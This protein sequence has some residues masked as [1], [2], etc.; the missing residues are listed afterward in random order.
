MD[1]RKN[2][3]LE[4]LATERNYVGI[5]KQIVQ[6]F[7]EPL[8]E[9]SEST[10][11]F[12][13]KTD[14]RLLFSEIKVILALNKNFLKDLE[15]VVKKSSQPI[16]SPFLKYGGLFRWY[17]IYICNFDKSSA[18][19][20]QLIKDNVAFKEFIAQAEA[21]P[22][23]NYMDLPS[24]MI[25]PVQRIPQYNLLL[26]DIANNTSES[27]SDHTDT[28]RAVK[29]MNV[30]GHYINE[31]KR[32]SENI[33]KVLSIS[34]SIQGFIL[35]PVPSRRF[36]L[37]DEFDVLSE[38]IP[39][40]S[41]VTLFGFNDVVLVSTKSEN[42]FKVIDHGYYHDKVALMSDKALDQSTA[43]ELKIKSKSIQLMAPSVTRKSIWEYH[44]KKFS[45]IASKIK[46]QKAKHLRKIN[47]IQSLLTVKS[48]DLTSSIKMPKTPRNHKKMT[49]GK[50]TSDVSDKTRDSIEAAVNL[51][52]KNE[53]FNSID[54]YVKSLGIT[55]HYIAPFENTK[56]YK[57]T[58]KA[59]LFILNRSFVMISERCKIVE[60]LH[61]L[62][63]TTLSSPKHPDIIIQTNDQ[64]IQG[65]SVFCDDIIHQ[66]RKCFALS[67][68]GIPK[69]L[70]WVLDIEPWR[71]SKIVV[72]KEKIK[73]GGFERTYK[74]IC[75]WLNHTIRSDVTFDVSNFEGEEFNLSRL[76]DLSN[77]DIKAITMALWYNRYFKSFKCHNI[78]LGKDVLICI[79][80]L[81]RQNTVLEGVSFSHNDIS[82]DGSSVIQEFFS[83]TSRKLRY[84]EISSNFLEDKGIS[85][86]LKYLDAQK[87]CPINTLI[88]R[89]V[90]IGSK[91]IV[92]LFNR[93]K[94]TTSTYYCLSTLD[95]SGNKMDN[96]GSA[97]LAA[98][99][100]T[101]C[102]VKDLNI[103]DTQARIGPILQSVIKGCIYLQKL[104]ISK[105]K[106]TKKDMPPLISFLKKSDSLQSLDI[107]ET[108]I[109]GGDLAELLAT[110]SQNPYLN[111]VAVIA[112]HN[113][114]GS[115]GAIDISPYLD[116]LKGIRSLSLK[117]NDFADEGVASICKALRNRSCLSSLW[118]DGNFKF[119]N[120][121]SRDTMV[122]SLC[123]LV[124][125]KFGSLKTLS[126][127][128]INKNHS[129][130][131]QDII[132]IIKSLER[133]KLEVIDF[134]GHKMGNAGTYAL[135]RVIAV[136]NYLKDIKFDENNIG[137]EGLS[138]IVDSISNRISPLNVVIPIVDISQMI[139][140]ETEN[141]NIK[142]LVYSLQFK[143]LELS[144][145]LNLKPVDEKRESPIASIKTPRKAKEKH[146]S[147]H[148]PKK[149][150]SKNSP[151][152]LK[153]KDK[154]SSDS[155]LSNEIRNPIKLVG[156][157]ESITKR[158]RR[159][160]SSLTRT[161]KS[162]FERIESL[163][164]TA[165][166][167]LAEVKTIKSRDSLANLK[168][169]YALK[170][171]SPTS[172][173]TGSNIEFG[174][175][176]EMDDSDDSSHSS[177]DSLDV[178]S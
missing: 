178:D 12:I 120:A 175:N 31:K 173:K 171:T 149:K 172:T 144:K 113:G 40:V 24:L 6:Y 126:I 107:S 84:L 97:A 122:H 18:T 157:A 66:I 109:S 101:P 62:D 140:S 116:S 72:H 135:S 94:K 52:I 78:A 46:S 57:A 28:L 65:I 117:E 63:I 152:P 160:S 153:K 130:L 25:Q 61:L 39:G 98:Y 131:K 158:E 15:G 70:A 161:R 26:A 104:D 4:I 139:L 29:L 60:R 151:R 176:K 99:L 74:S 114:L 3:I 118:L 129:Q 163:S 168:D 20:K 174:Y 55:A 88:L 89:D 50:D 136:N 43:C 95:I 145:Q 38:S 32:E 34:E 119:K 167:D 8:E 112:D 115:L 47:Q 54:S 90:Y 69:K 14:I 125:S 143:L 51:I 44:V 2:A 22:D 103:S 16:S 80:D 81:L 123:G 64:S 165:A 9:N 100:G 82:K 37:E 5:L 71:T 162:P 141:S 58:S 148:K 96:D 33:S 48:N 106:I 93:L 41:K 27:H 91:G 146:A 86:I 127:S 1:K 170:Q 156:S 166:L 17:H 77:M 87:E 169:R 147:K 75:D 13:S 53:G 35:K 49:S 137:I 83:F 42:G 102:A 138:S 111:N 134:S 150:T 23:M 164:A 159:R 10:E 21:R 132:P 79:A 110:I 73:Q 133:S 124:S 128:H 121:K 11:P 7:V 155:S 45:E 67:F 76:K 68:P 142:D 59:S 56:N 19:F 36:Y 105:N 177:M 92:K 154:D 30:V 108:E 85:P